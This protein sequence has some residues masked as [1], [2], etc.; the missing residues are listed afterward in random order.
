MTKPSFVRRRLTLAAVVLAVT[1]LVAPATAAPASAGT[2]R[3]PSR[4]VKVVSYNLYLGADLTPL[5]GA[6]SIPDLTQ[7]AG[8]VYA[9]MQST[10]FPER[11][12]ALARLIKRQRPDVIGLQE[13]ALWETAPLTSAE[14]TTT[15]DFL[16]ILQHALRARGLHYRVAATNTNFTNATLPVPIP[17]SATTK[18]QFTDHDVV[19]VRESPRIMTTNA[20]PHTYAASLTLGI[21]GVPVPVVR[22]W[23]T[24]DIT[25]G[26]RSFRLANTH[27]E[28]FDGEDGP[29]K[30]AQA[31][32]LAADLSASPLPVIA[33]GDINSQP[34]D[35]GNPNTTA[36]G[37]VAAAG[38]DEV[39]PAAHPQAPCT[40]FT[41]GQAADLLNPESLIDHRIDVVFYDPDAFRAKRAVVIGEEQK[42]RSRP[43]GLWPSDHAGSAATLRIR[44][45]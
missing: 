29:V 25:L 34:T 39:W 28:A 24:V 21:L 7:R 32:E 38:F 43:T 41:S 12:R 1:G 31:M 19:L 8:Q 23:S 11:S 14:F 17:I 2:H 9:Q 3:H 18:A 20:Q 5:F 42:D 36:Y 4:D 40:G 27:F 22:G 44:K 10:N 26:G 33:V 37:I 6:Q 35:C 16:A 30:T 13:V 45:H 15:Y